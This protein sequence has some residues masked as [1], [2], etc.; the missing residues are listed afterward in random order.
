MLNSKS[1]QL[2]RMTNTHLKP[3]NSIYRR[4]IITYTATKPLVQYNHNPNKK[5]DTKPV[6]IVSSDNDDIETVSEHIRV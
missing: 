3:M 4:N 5:S 2:L 6:I 1:L